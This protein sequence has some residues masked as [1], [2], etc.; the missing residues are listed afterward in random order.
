[1]KFMNFFGNQG[2]FEHLLEIIESSEIDENLNFRILV[3]FALIVA[4]PSVT[5]HRKFVEDFGKRIVDAIRK[6]LEGV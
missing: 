5:Y 4:K 2:F 3:D 1:M 6:R